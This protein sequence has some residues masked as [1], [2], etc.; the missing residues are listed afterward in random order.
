MQ[1]LPVRQRRQPTP[2]QLPVAP[3]PAHVRTCAS[4][5]EGVATHTVRFVRQKLACISLFAAMKAQHAYI[6]RGAVLKRRA[7][8]GQ[9][10]EMWWNRTS[11]GVNAYVGTEARGGTAKAGSEKTC[12]HLVE[13]LVARAIL[14]DERLEV[15]CL[16]GRRGRR[17]H[18]GSRPQAR[19]VSSSGAHGLNPLASRRRRPSAR[20]D[21]QQ[22]PPQRSSARSVCILKTCWQT[23]ARYLRVRPETC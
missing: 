16:G 3:T 4:R 7:L 21:K 6:F 5:L 18:K 2:L 14:E 22:R 9:R 19:Q 8:N 1:L 23:L 20:L 17:G 12:L 13:S 11:P 10:G 15:R